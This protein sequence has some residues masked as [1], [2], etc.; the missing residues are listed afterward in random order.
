[1]KS[2]KV[3]VLVKTQNADSGESTFVV[4]KEKKKW[5]ETLRAK[6]PELS[7]GKYADVLCVVGAGMNLIK[8]HGV[9]NEKGV[10]PIPFPIQSGNIR[11]TVVAVELV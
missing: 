7:E 4:V 10:L 1:M 3:G 2:K 8:E 5:E 6:L 9:P 11:V